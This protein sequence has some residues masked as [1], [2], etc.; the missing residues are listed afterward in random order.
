LSCAQTSSAISSLVHAEAT[1][2]SRGAGV[3]QSDTSIE[4]IPSTR[5]SPSREKSTS[6]QN[7]AC[8]IEVSAHGESM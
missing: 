8:E 4:R 5:P 6:V 1:L 2:P 7:W 3:S